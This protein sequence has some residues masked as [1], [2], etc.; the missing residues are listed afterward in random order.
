MK[1]SYLMIFKFYNRML[2]N[3]K[4]LLLLYKPFVWN[5]TCTQI[6]MNNT[7]FMLALWFLSKR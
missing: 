1:Y 7:I 2:T 4:I 3:K 6:F 5:T